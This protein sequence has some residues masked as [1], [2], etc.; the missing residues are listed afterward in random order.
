MKITLRQT[1]YPRSFTSFTQEKRDDMALRDAE[2]F[3]NTCKDL[4]AATF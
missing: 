2:S 4:I 3:P 1:I